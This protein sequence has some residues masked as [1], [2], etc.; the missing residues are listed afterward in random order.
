MESMTDKKE[1]R[2]YALISLVIAGVL[3]SVLFIVIFFISQNYQSPSFWIGAVGE[4]GLGYLTLI[5]PGRIK[6]FR[7]PLIVLA[8]IL[9]GALDQALNVSRELEPNS[10]FMVYLLIVFWVPL[11][12]NARQTVT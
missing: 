5:L 3:A 2:K 11:F 12:K 8:M 9:P 7:Y 4:L 6:I 10:A 1:I